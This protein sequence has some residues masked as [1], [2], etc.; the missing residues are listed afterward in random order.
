MHLVWTPELTTG[1]RL[2]DDQHKRL[3]QLFNDLNEAIARK[4][5]Q[6]A[7]GRTLT[8]LS[9]YV[10]AH[11]RM[12]EELMGQFGYQG[13]AG[14]HAAHEAMRI[15]VEDM[16]DQFNLIGVDPTQV[17]RVLRE[18]LVVHV[19]KEDQAMAEFLKDAQ[20]AP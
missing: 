11:F 9:V 1:N 2:I 20:Q 15:Q 4:E 10:V 16:V 5:G 17:M 14:H 13:L 8:A 18:W 7:V 12:E 3:F 6:E 19:Q